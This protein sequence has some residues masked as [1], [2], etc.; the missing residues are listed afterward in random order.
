MA[1]GDCWWDTYFRLRY[2]E[3]YTSTSDRYYWRTTTREYPLDRSRS[4]WR[5]RSRERIEVDSNN[6]E[7]NIRDRR[8]RYGTTHYR[9][10]SR[11]RERE[12]PGHSTSYYYPTRRCSVPGCTVRYCAGYCSWR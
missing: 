8:P 3:S 12:E 4:C 9:V 11:V 2:D 5:E 1:W 7:V 6:W 10:S